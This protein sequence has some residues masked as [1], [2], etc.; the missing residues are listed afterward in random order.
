MFVVIAAAALVAGVSAKLGEP[1]LS[2]SRQ[3]IV[4]AAMALYNQ[5][6]H[7][8]YTEGAWGPV[9]YAW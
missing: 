7:E 5:R 3:G 6:A 2:G 1:K 9:L 8:H 4:D